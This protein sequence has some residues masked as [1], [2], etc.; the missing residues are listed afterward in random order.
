MTDPGKQTSR[1]FQFTAFGGLILCSAVI[2]GVNAGREPAIAQEI[3]PCP[4]IKTACTQAGFKQGFA[5]EGFGLMVDCIRPIMQGVPQRAKA[6]KPLPAIDAT[7]VASCKATN[8][9]FGQQKSTPSQPSGKD[10]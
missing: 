10:G 4:Q 3:A 2:A 1:F 7:L 8:P 5:K 6:T 9:N